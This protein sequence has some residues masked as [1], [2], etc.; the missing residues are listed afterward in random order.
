[1]RLH[2]VGLAAL[3]MSCSS[4]ESQ[5]EDASRDG[6]AGDTDEPGDASVDADRDALPDTTQDVDE[7]ESSD[8]E[9]LDDTEDA[10]SADADSDGDVDRLTAA[11]CFGDLLSTDSLIAMDYDQF[12]PTIGSH[13]LGTDHQD[14]LGVERVV[15]LGDSITV[16]SPPTLPA[17]F[18]RNR[19]A[20]DLADAFGLERP[21][22][23]W[24]Q[25]DPVNGVSLVRESGDFACC[26][27]WG[28]KTDD[29][30]RDN[31]QIEDC[32]PEDERHKTTLVVM[33]MGGND[34]ASITEDGID[35]VPIPDIWA[36]V[37]EFVDLQ[38][39]AV[40]WF[41]EDPDRFPGGIYVV[42]ANMFEFTDGTGD[43]TAC[44]AAGLAGFGAEWDD[45]D[46][47]AQ[48][49]IWANEQYMSI[50]TETG[51]DM[52]FLLEG[53]CGHGWN[54]DNPAAPCYRGP[55]TGRWFDLSCIHPNPEGHHQI[56]NMFMAVVM[57]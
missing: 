9:R 1:M 22:L 7:D 24:R 43:V 21:G 50:A 36:E 16:G 53:F 3:V 51:T 2:A 20:N 33:T 13:C 25:V 44:P 47:L 37:H 4:G 35:G 48:M 42:F 6:G 38:R 49:V 8:A 12:S 45:P 40:S 29:L 41:Y 26:A 15:F 18:Y 28:A 31:T 54:N 52:I 11:E 32:F 30:I 10:D 57:E 19:L 23:L 27:K 14:I 5:P 39:Q 34:I 46:A 55:G 17:D 56:A